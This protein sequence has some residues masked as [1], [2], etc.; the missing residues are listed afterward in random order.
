V[1]T[2]ASATCREWSRWTLVGGDN[3]IFGAA[4]EFAHRWTFELHTQHNHT[5]RAA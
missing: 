3:S 2:L 1:S 4:E 5:R